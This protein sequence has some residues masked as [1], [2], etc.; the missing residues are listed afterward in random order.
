MT[1][2]RPLQVQFQDYL[3]ERPSAILDRIAE[4]PREDRARLLEIYRNA[5]LSRLVEA[6]GNDAP[7][8]RRLAGEEAFDALARAY[9]RAHPSIHRS[10][11]WI[12]D[13]L[14]SFLARTPP[15]NARPALAEMASF[16]WALAAAF[17]AADAVPETVAGLA[18][19]PPQAW[20]SIR[21]ALHPS[22]Q[23]LDLRTNVPEIWQRSDEAIDSAEPEIVAEAFVPWLIWRLDLSV[24]F[25]RL[26]EDEAWAYDRMAEGLPFEAVCEG[27]SR[28][29]AE[30][31]VALRAAGLLKSWIE[32]GI[33]ARIDHD[34]PISS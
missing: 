19:I 31:E 30:D 3:L 1:A 18:A 16:E 7:Q 29:V 28:W 33:V 22:A 27:L 32:T 34:V 23:R 8:L 12:G 4:A 2:L 24:K 21:L 10:I 9:L 25:R 5:Y 15:Y 26:A 11:R 17:D 13:G 14:A 6:L 20:G